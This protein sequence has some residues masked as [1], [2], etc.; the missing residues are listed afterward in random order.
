MA[1]RRAEKA[2]RRAFACTS[3]RTNIACACVVPKDNPVAPTAAIVA[4]H[5]R[6]HP[7]RRQPPADNQHQLSCSVRATTR[8]N[9][10]VQLLVVCSLSSQHN[11]AAV[12]QYYQHY[13]YDN[14][15]ML[16]SPSS[17]FPPLSTYYAFP[18]N[19]SKWIQNRPKF[20]MKMD[21]FLLIN[22][23]R[24]VRNVPLGSSVSVGGLPERDTSIGVPISSKLR[25][26]T[27]THN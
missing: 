26:H 4:G 19:P 16:R 11:A 1:P 15:L 7:V 6:A 14:I 22:Y 5:F 25:A 8:H 20:P 2:A 9:N 10:A 18:I 13:Q 23:K 21:L 24:I 17:V 27:H 3:I 12:K